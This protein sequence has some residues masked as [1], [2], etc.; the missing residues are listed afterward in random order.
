MFP[1][2]STLPAGRGMLSEMATLTG[3]HLQ[4]PRTVADPGSRAPEQKAQCRT[5]KLIPA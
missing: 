2:L 4:E 3:S 5:M 1:L